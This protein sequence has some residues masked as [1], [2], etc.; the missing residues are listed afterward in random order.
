MRLL[1]HTR[2]E[3]EPVVSAGVL[4]GVPVRAH[5]GKE[6][7]YFSILVSIKVFFVSSRIFRFKSY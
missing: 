1:V 3:R 5:V 2:E 7:A 6:L 4:T